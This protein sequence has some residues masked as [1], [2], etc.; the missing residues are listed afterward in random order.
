MQ[1]EVL[2]SRIYDALE[3]PKAITISDQEAKII[4]ASHVDATHTKYQTRD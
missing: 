4:F 2:F 3:K 1:I